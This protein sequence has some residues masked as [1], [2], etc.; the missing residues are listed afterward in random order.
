MSKKVL[1]V[2]IVFVVVAAMALVLIHRKH[3]L[4]NM[5]PPANPPVPVAT[6]EVKQGEASDGVATV[7]LIQSETAATAAAQLPG[8]ILEMRF[9]EGDTV[10]K[11]QIM[12]AIDPRKLRGRRAIGA[13]APGAAEEDYAKQKAIFERDKALGGRRGHLPTGL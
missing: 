9:H 3:Q 11:G 12:A 2:L 6:S 1:A 5:A 13:G 7:A 8:A 10:K 4:A